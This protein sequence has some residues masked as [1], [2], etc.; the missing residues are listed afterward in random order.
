MPASSNP[1]VRGM[2]VYVIALLV[3]GMIVG[4]I[5]TAS[6]RPSNPSEPSAAEA[7]QKPPEKSNPVQ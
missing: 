4:A 3:L 7:I 2:L 1:V 6:G 5:Y